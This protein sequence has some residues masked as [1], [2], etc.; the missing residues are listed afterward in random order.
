MQNYLRPIII[1]LST[2]ASYTS[3]SA[4]AKPTAVMR[5]AHSPSTLTL[6]VTLSIASVPRAPTQKQTQ[7]ITL[8][9]TYGGGPAFTAQQVPPVPDDT[10]ACASLDALVGSCTT[11][12]SFYILPLF[13]QAQRLSN[14][15][16]WDTVV[17]ECFDHLTVL[18]Q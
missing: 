8:N 7:T 6:T 5:Q 14:V 17:T 16:P 15:G 9:P 4:Q 3:A 10:P 11:L 2:F 13:A 12:A 18:G 1:T